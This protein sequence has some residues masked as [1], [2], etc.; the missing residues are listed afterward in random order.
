[1]STRI[2]RFGSVLVAS[3]ELVVWLIGRLF[4]RADNIIAGGD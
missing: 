4:T 2:Q 3:S 1:M